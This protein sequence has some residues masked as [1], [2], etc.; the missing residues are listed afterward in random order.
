MELKIPTSWEDI[1]LGQYI[2]LRPI[3]QTKEDDIKRVINILCVL[4]GKKREEIRNVTIPDFHKLI[5]KMSFLNDPLPKQLNKRRFL[6]G[7]KWYE[8][9]LDA[10]K[11]LFGEYISVMEILQ[12]SGDNEDLLFN[13][14]HKILTVI[15]RPV[16]KTL[17]G[18]KSVNIDGDLIR[19]TAN[20]FYNNMPITIAYPIGVFFYQRYPTLTETIKTS[21][22]EEA[23]KKIK[24]VKTDLQKAGVGGV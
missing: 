6:I 3:L 15:C 19:E 5:K 4:T 2:E 14:L 22:M 18:F 13:N 11:M 20:N 24:E 8:F 9:K 17:F 7:G 1:T 16:Y 12:K 21:L 23:E 10:K